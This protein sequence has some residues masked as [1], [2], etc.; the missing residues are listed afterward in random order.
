MHTSKHHPEVV[1]FWKPFIMKRR[2]CSFIATTQRSVDPSQ[3]FIG[4]L[5]VQR[6]KWVCWQEAD[7]SL[8]KA[9]TSCI[10]QNT[11]VWP[12]G[13]STWKKAVWKGLEADNS[14]TCRTTNPAWREKLSKH[15][16][17]QRIQTSTWKFYLIGSAFQ[18]GLANHLKVSIEH[19]P[20]GDGNWH[21]HI[22][23]MVCQC[24]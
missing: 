19:L 1:C 5:Q 14:G 7:P 8:W 20:S 17:H 16:L 15:S 24:W 11:D 10:I 3:P 23:I 21:S 22:C 18:Q 9:E 13:I 12:A 6:Y 2:P 4:S